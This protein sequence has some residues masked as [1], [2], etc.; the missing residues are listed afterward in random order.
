MKMEDMEGDEV[1]DASVEEESAVAA[2]MEISDMDSDK[3]SSDEASEWKSISEEADF[4]FSPHPE[5]FFNSPRLVM[6]QLWK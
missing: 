2:K 3:E 4:Q 5:I 1:S 6:K